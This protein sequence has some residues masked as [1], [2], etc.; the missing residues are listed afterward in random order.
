MSHIFG[1]VAKFVPSFKSDSILVVFPLLFKTSG[2]AI[3]QG[4]GD[5][6]LQTS[7]KRLSSKPPTQRAVKP[8]FTG[9]GRRTGHGNKEFRKNRHRFWWW[10][11]FQSLSNAARMWSFHKG[12][13]RKVNTTKTKQNCF[14]F[15]A[16]RG[17]SLLIPI[18]KG[19]E[20][21]FSAMLDKI[22]EQHS[23]YDGI[24]LIWDNHQAHITAAIE[25]KAHALGISIVRLPTYSPNLNPIE[26]LW[27]AIKGKLA[28]HGLIENLA[29]LNQLLEEAFEI[30]SESL[31]CAKKWI[32]DFWNVIFWK[33][34]PYS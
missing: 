34:P 29:H 12:K 28:Q 2:T 32:D 25:K 26:R 23:D 31:S 22:K 33:S 18:K 3:T 8:A 7:T 19:N 9:S 24:I 17:K 21:T 1:L 5:V 6:L 11:T 20:V 16:I 10:S 15:Y 30:A 27:K 14:G 13:I 4:H